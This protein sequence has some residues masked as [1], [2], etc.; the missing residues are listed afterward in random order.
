MKTFDVLDP[1]IS[2]VGHYFLEA[3][4][5]TGK[6]FTIENVVP[7]ILLESEPAIT[8]DQILIVTF[9]RAA[10]R[11]L[12]TRIHAHLMEIAQALQKGQGGP[13]YIQKYFLG[14]KETLD[15]AR[16]KIEEACFCFEKAQIFTLHGFALAMLQRFAF[17]AKKFI[18]SQPE[19]SQK[20]GQLLSYIKDFLRIGLHKEFLSESQ[21]QRIYNQRKVGKNST[22]LCKEIIT[23]LEKAK[24][25]RSY[26]T[27][28]QQYD[29]WQKALSSFSSMK[30]DDLWRN[31]K[32]RAPRLVG[33]SKWAAQTK[34]IFSFIEKGACSFSEWDSLLAE[35]ELFLSQ[36]KPEKET[37]ERDFYS[38][39][40]E[41]MRS[42]LISL[43]QEATDVDILMLQLAK[44]AEPY[45]QKG[46]QEHSLH[47][48]DDFIYQ[49]KEGLQEDCF[50]SKIQNS[51]K[52]LIIDEFQDT[53]ELQWTIFSTLFLSEE[54]K[55]PILYLVGDPKQSIY[56][57][58]SAD[59]YVYMQAKQQFSED[60]QCC[61]ITNF[62]SHPDLIQALNTFFSFDLPSNWMFLPK[63]D[64]GLLVQKVLPRNDYPSSFEDNT[65]GRIHFFACEEKNEKF[66]RWPTLE[67]EEDCLIPYM[68]LEVLRLKVERGI[69]YRQVAILVKDRFQAQ[70]VQKIFST[71]KIPCQMQKNINPQGLSFIAMQELIA[72]LI[73]PKDL[74]ILKKFLGGAMMAFTEKELQGGWDNALLQK[75]R[76][77][78]LF[79]AEKVLQKGFGVFFSDFL[80]ADSSLEG[81]TVA[82]ALLLRED[83]SL[84]FE[85]RQLCQILIQ[86]SP[87]GYHSSLAIYEFLSMLQQEE[88]ANLLHEYAEQ[89]EDQV[90]VM[91]LHKSKGLEFDVV[92]AL[93]LASRHT[94]QDD[95]MIVENNGEKELAARVDEKIFLEQ[96]K[97]LDA[98]KLRQLYVALTRAKERVYIPWVQPS[99]KAEIDYGTASPLELLLGS[100]GLALSSYEKIYSNISSISTALLESFQDRASV[101]CEKISTLNTTIAALEKDV[102]QLRSPKGYVPS[103]SQGFIRSFSSLIFDKGEKEEMY[104]TKATSIEGDLSLPVGAETGVVIHAILEALCKADLHRGISEKGKELIAQ[105]CN[106]TLLEGKEEVVADMVFSVLQTKIFSKVGAFCLSD[107]KAIDMRPEVEFLYPIGNSFMKGFIDL[108]FRYEG[109]Y[110][111]LDWK[112]NLLEED[113]VFAIQKCMQEHRYDVQAAIYC[114][115]LARYIALFDERPF[116][117]LFGGAIYF[118]MRNKQPWVFDPDLSVVSSIE[119]ERF[120]CAKN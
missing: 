48:P 110:F 93:S 84:Y 96:K 45:Y 54:K 95:Y 119:E 82:E 38:E 53:D 117:S 11:E 9:T 101:T 24:S 49:L 120:L 67:I 99:F 90:H 113:S 104:F 92:F 69:S 74:A 63:L 108:I 111:L 47:A 91:T 68:A 41:E 83:T 64:Q 106:K 94:G 56:S 65:K 114:S 34:K 70:R 77:Y 20:G 14:G 103:F 17:D 4:A 10:T 62:R 44:A 31:Y 23:L 71:Y 88:Y 73:S 26:P 86:Y 3:S 39:L 37:M 72:C 66:A 81:Y 76:E 15:V 79:A 50:V 29:R 61:L 57:F 16:R 87:Q 1:K 116:S 107:I 8:I 28:K 19:D 78:F 22:F 42:T 115:A 55:I 13:S 35:K 97:E 85:M 59:V 6:T 2:A 100:R 32:I 98:E 105:I 80:H 118:F 30:E 43:H 12:K 52:A 112:T 102:P 51:Y 18:G 40:F 33:S 25:I 36:I 46:K 60:C 5:G 75:T 7:R 89:E 27:A 58:R 109:K 21:I